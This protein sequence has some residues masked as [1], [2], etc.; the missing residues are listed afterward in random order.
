MMQSIADDI[1]IFK[2]AASAVN[3]AKLM[4][5]T[6]EK[7]NSQCKDERNIRKISGFGI[8]TS[9]CV[10]IPRS[11]VYNGKAFD[12]VNTICCSHRSGEVLVTA[13]VYSDIVDSGMFRT[14]RAIPSRLNVS[15]NT[16]LSLFTLIFENHFEILKQTQLSSART[17]K[18]VHF[19]DTTGENV[20]EQE[21]TA[22]ISARSSTNPSW[23]NLVLVL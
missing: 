8:D 6:L 22:L 7:W 11:D 17:S 2:N 16:S 21:K 20:L 23:A 5:S 4:L 12:V 3:S 19:G 14:L 9:V 13:N 18:H 1:Y 15:S 10:Y